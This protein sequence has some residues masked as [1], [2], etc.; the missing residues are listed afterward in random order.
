M[1]KSIV[2]AWEDNKSNLEQ[3]FKA[4]NPYEI[5]YATI[6]KQLF[7][8]VINPYGNE[9]ENSFSFNAEDITK[10][11]NGDY[12]GTLIFILHKDTYQPDVS[13]YIMTFVGYGSCSVCDTLKGI[14]AENYEDTATEEQVKEFMTLSLH[15]IQRME[16]LCKQE[17]N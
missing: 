15:L 1:I 4:T 11:D 8:L 16:W 2:R 6:V 5:S 17:N 3:Y 12:Q 10:I 13:D 14:Q 7:E 9:K